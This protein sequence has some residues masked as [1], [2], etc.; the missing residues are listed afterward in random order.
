[1]GPVGNGACWQLGLKLHMFGRPWPPL[2][3]GEHS[4][5][6]T[7]ACMHEP[8]QCVNLIMILLL[9]HIHRYSSLTMSSLQGNRQTPPDW[10]GVY[11][12]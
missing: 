3:P 12:S 9:L 5:L 6:R 2:K 1:M 7:R 10:Q 11:N 8:L 4:V